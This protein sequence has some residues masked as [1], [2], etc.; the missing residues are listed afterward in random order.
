MAMA[1][2]A[3]LLTS[4]GPGRDACISSA[5]DG[6]AL[7]TFWISRAS[8]A[9]VTTF[10]GLA[11]V[12]LLFLWR[13][14]RVA[15][16]DHQAF[17]ALLALK[18]AAGCTLI[19]LRLSFLLL[20][21]NKSSENVLFLGLDLFS[22]CLLF[23]LSFFEQ[24][25]RFRPPVLSCSYLFFA[26]ILDLTRKTIFGERSNAKM[27]NFSVE[28]DKSAPGTLQSAM[29]LCQL[30]LFVLESCGKRRWIAWTT[31]PG[32]TWKRHS[33][34][35][36]SSIISLATYWWMLPLL[37]QGYRTPLILQQLYSLDKS[38]V[39]HPTIK[40]AKGARKTDTQLSPHE[41]STWRI[42]AW[43]WKPLGASVLLP[44][45]PR[46]CL[47]AF[48]FGQ[49][50]FLRSLLRWLSD[51]DEASSDGTSPS[52]FISMAVMIYF[53]IAVSTALYWYYQERF[54][55]SIRGFLVASIYQK[56]M[57]LR[58]ETAKSSSPVTLMGADV[59]RIYTGVQLLHEVWANTLQTTL[60]ATLLY[61]LLGPALVAP[62]C[63]L[64]LTLFGSL[65][66][67]HHAPRYQTAWMARVQHRTEATASFLA[68][69]KDLRISGLS[70][71]AAANIKRAREDEIALGGGAAR[72]LTALSAS[73]S[74]VPAA[75]A[76]ALAFAFGP[77]VLGTTS[78]FTALAYLTLG[79][80]P[81]LVVLQALPILTAT[82]ACLRRVKVFLEQP[83][84]VKN[85][86]YDDDD[87]AA[88]SERFMDVGYDEQPNSCATQVAVEVRNG[89]FGWMEDSTV[90]Q[91]INLTLCRGSITF[92]V[93]PV[94]SGKSTL[95]MAL[96]G[97]VPYSTGSVSLKSGRRGYCAQQPFLYNASIRENITGFSSF[98]PARYDEVLQAT[99]L[100][101]DLEA[102]LDGDNTIIGSG[103]GSL[104]GGQ[105]QRV[106]L[107]RALYQHAD[108]LVLDDVF[109]GLDG[110]TCSQVCESVFGPSG[111]LRR[112]GTTVILCTHS[113]E[114]MK[115]ADHVVALSQDGRI[116]QD[117]SMARPFGIATAN[118]G[119]HAPSGQ[120][121][122]SGQSNVEVSHAQSTITSMSR[123]IGNKA[124]SPGQPAT[125]PSPP[126]DWDIYRYWLSSI[127]PLPIIFYLPLVA[128]VGFCTSFQTIWVDLWSKDST[129][130]HQKHAFPFWMC[131]YALLG[132]GVILCTLPA[133]LLMLRT[134]TRLAG[135]NLHHVTVD[136]VV[137]SSLHFLSST[138]VGKVLNL[139]SQDFNIIDA[140]LPR[141]TNNFTICL[142]TAIGQAF[143]IG[144]SSPWLAISYPIFVMLLLGIQRLYLPTSKRLRFMD[145]EAKT[146][147]YTNFLDT[148]AGL[149]TI[150]SFG[151][152]P[153][154][155]A[156]NNALLEDSQR[157]LYLLAMAQQWLRMLM[158]VLV[159]LM[160]VG[161]VTVAT[162]QV[163]S[164]AGQVG[165]GLVS[166]ITLG[167]TLTVTLVA[168]TGLEISLGAVSRLK[169]FEE[170]TE[171]ENVP[172]EEQDDDQKHQLYIP[173]E[174]WPMTGCVQ[175]QN[176]EASYNLDGKDKVLKGVNLT[177]A[178][179]EKLAITGRTGSGKSTI[180]AL[181]LRLLDP[182]APSVETTAPCP[183]QIDGLPLVTINRTTLRERIIALSQDPVFLPDTTATVREN[184]DLW[185]LASD[186][187]CRA[188]LR[189]V[190]PSLESLELKASMERAGLSGGQMQ[191]FCLARAVLRRRVK[192]RRTGVDGGLLLLDEMGASVDSETEK[193]IMGVIEEEFKAYT[194]VMITH[195]S[196]MAAGCD[197]VV[198]LDDGRV[199]E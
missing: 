109:G 74:Q 95:C 116:V 177:I 163:G 111:L 133:A 100:V 27:L 179:G 64:F 57:R 157:P 54:Q 60:A 119:T 12:R 13:C 149:V 146:P 159:A 3:Q 189:D 195:R 2:C 186:D 166:I 135:T 37:W 193:V 188:A 150:R 31:E 34:E 96:L 23:V 32:D 152:V 131:I 123:S 65:T 165:A 79:T 170:E 15:V 29:I 196:G 77:H 99:K 49:T 66:I 192:M 48:A 130:A 7:T 182:I 89:Y 180:V 94:A 25:K 14:K 115:V 28:V 137:H 183:I 113:T 92:V 132:I 161:L 124:L 158:N 147:L 185:G 33:P 76:P 85:D 35:E 40:S 168:Y 84:I 136:T 56:T 190:H 55:A 68:C 181:L 122:A 90:L 83:H 58:L 81:L 67:S 53:G 47:I 167:S 24:L 22:A 11:V 160:A 151:W 139:F 125:S 191:L 20:S 82:M 178:P 16:A 175:M 101:P 62:A 176:V 174:V 110:A 154:Q 106:S 5:D 1:G 93:G 102:M 69:L 148:V 86:G 128:G 107:G 63:L 41:I 143:V 134:A 117:E 98:D 198:V 127:G 142:A 194:A 144:W 30:L 156:R 43:L 75:L 114:F 50:V 80:A 172:N 199:I 51:R 97:E 108:I 42:L 39:L 121:E 70:Q 36:T 164:S 171:Q 187:E 162:T 120:S 173:A 38:L 155:L 18:L 52:F 145:L 10:I 61:P 44:V 71:P 141:M 21:T 105:R 126:V 88:S 9:I 73:L 197:R 8:F 91:D 4:H 169:S 104:S 87:D 59:E 184:L 103:G 6:F 153:Q 19:G 140:Q 45:L 129:S 72:T 118:G 112:R 17:A 26:F 78:A 46:L 138:D